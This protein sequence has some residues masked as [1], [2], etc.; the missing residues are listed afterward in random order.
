MD[1]QFLEF[2]G[3]MMLS[4]AKGQQQLEDIMQWMAGSAK[5]LKEVY[6]TFCRMYGIEPG[7]EKPAEYMAFWQKALGEFRDS[8]GEIMTMMDLVPRR[9]YIAV[10]RENQDLKMRVSELEEAVRR[11]RT[12]LDER[13]AFPSE[14]I[15]G[16]QDLIDDQAQK[17]QD[18]MKSMTAV[19]DERSK[20][21]GAQSKPSKGKQKTKP[22]GKSGSAGG[23][24]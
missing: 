18:F 16:F 23:K 3:T 21:S 15:K 6:G 2:W 14:G 19:F 11:L 17:Y 5:D 9:D 1:K 22:A 13:A 4:A 10:S 7:Q 20:T 24:K 12:L 8:Y